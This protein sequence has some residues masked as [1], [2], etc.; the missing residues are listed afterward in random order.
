M[1]VS[2]TEETM[3]VRFR[4]FESMY[5]SRPDLFEEAAGFASKIPPDRLISISH[6]CDKSQGVVNSQVLGRG[7][8]GERGVIPKAA[9][10][11]LD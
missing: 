6:S 1:G 5:E 9:W 8:G 7:L 11:L 4:L 2:R 10:L 3:R